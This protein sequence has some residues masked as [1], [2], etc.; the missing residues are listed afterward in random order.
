MKEL[1][2]LTKQ[3]NDAE[4]VLLKTMD[5]ITENLGELNTIERAGQL[6]PELYSRKCALVEI[7]ENL[8]AWSEAK[9]YGYTWDVETEFP[10]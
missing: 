8:M 6:T 4:G 5:Y 1:T 9:N 2:R 3:Q 10:I 7:L